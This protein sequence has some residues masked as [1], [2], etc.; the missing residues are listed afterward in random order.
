MITKY[1]NFINEKIT[2]FDKEFMDYAIEIFLK[3]IDRIMGKGGKGSFSF[4]YVVPLIK[5]DSKLIKDKIKITIIF[6]PDRKSDNGQQ[7]GGALD[8]NK[9]IRISTRGWSGKQ[10]SEIFS[11]YVHELQHIPQRYTQIMN[12]DRGKEKGSY[13][14]YVQKIRERSKKSGYIIKPMSARKYYHNVAHDQRNSEKEANLASLLYCLKYDF[15]EQ[16]VK[17][18]CYNGSY[19]T[20]TWRQFLNKLYYVGVPIEKMREWKEKLIEKFRLE[21]LHPTC[22]YITYSIMYNTRC[23]GFFK[24]NL[25]VL[26]MIEMD[27]YFA[28]EMLKMVEKEWDT[29]K[30]KM[31]EEDKKWREQWMKNWNK[32]PSIDPPSKKSEMTYN[33]VKEFLLDILG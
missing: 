1:D 4:E 7:T 3:K 10:K 31:E 19:F 9:W 27:K 12:Y 13:S 17:D 30:V 5:T 6:D 29:S 28:E 18:A 23:W 21:L 24:E 14:D 2:S 26:V 25:P 32:E 22:R 11:T 15:I 20:F 8:T 33:S 16:G